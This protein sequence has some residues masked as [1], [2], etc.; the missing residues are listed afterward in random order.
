MP[1]AY[2]YPLVVW[3]KQDALRM[4][5]ICRMKQ[6][7][8]YHSPRALLRWGSNAGLPRLLRDQVGRI[9][10]LYVHEC[11][12]RERFTCGIRHRFCS[13]QIR[14]GLKISG[15]ECAPSQ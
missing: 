4:Q 1:F 9:G 8:R 6:V 11:A 12:S 15:T 13:V 5:L 10:V 2:D 3:A 14:S 7:L